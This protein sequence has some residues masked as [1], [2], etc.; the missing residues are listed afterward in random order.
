MI[1]RCSSSENGTGVRDWPQ[2]DRVTLSRW[3][4]A[5]IKR[6]AGQE[7]SMT[8]ESKQS[9]FE[10]FARLIIP[11]VATVGVFF[12]QKQKTV[13]LGLI[14]V[15]II[16]LLGGEGPK[17]WRWFRDRKA[18][19]VEE[20]IAVQAMDELKGW[21]HKFLEFT[22]TQTSDSFYGLVWSRLCESHQEYFE[23]L[24]IPPL[25]LFCDFS[26]ILL[27]RTD[28]HKPSRV[29]LKQSIEELNSLVGLY[30]RYCVCPIYDKIPLKARPEIAR[31]FLKSNLAGDLIQFRE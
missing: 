24:Y 12:Q 18:Q 3:K 30:S 4:S 23:S 8:E 29:V 14:A 13:A 21:I 19:K 27:M 7:I 9:L 1:H 11:I 22:T 28:D 10:R 25:Q 6:R 26:R 17:V 31:I 5:Q 20:R 2:R 15:A 16:S